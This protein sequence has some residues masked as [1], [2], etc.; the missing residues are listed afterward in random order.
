M[1]REKLDTGIDKDHYDKMG[2]R[3]TLKELAKEEDSQRH[4]IT[5]EKAALQQEDPAVDD[6]A[7]NTTACGCGMQPVKSARGLTRIHGSTIRR[8]CSRIP[9]TISFTILGC[10]PQVT[11]EPLST[12]AG[13]GVNHIHVGSRINQRNLYELPDEKGSKGIDATNNPHYKEAQ[14]PGNMF[15]STSGERLKETSINFIHEYADNDKDQM[16][17]R[18]ADRRKE[19]NQEIHN[20]HT[21]EL[22]ASPAPRIRRYSE[23]A[24]LKEKVGFTDSG[25]RGS[26]PIAAGSDIN[27]GSAR[28]PIIT[29]MAE[30][31]DGGKHENRQVHEQ[32]DTSEDQQDNNNDDNDDF[33]Y[34]MQST[35]TCSTRKRTRTKSRQPRRRFRRCPRDQESTLSIFFANVT[36]LGEQPRKHLCPRN[37]HIVGVAETH[38]RGKK[39]EEVE[40]KLGAAGLVVSHSPASISAKSDSG[41]HGG[42]MLLHKP[43]LQ[44]AIPAAAEGAKGQRLPEGDVA[45]KHFRIKGLHLI[46][47]SAYFEDGVGLQGSNLKK[48]HRLEELRGGGHNHLIVLG[49]F[50]V[51]PAEWHC[52]HYLNLLNC[53]IVT[54]GD[55]GTCKTRSGYSL[56]DYALVDNDIRG[57]VESFEQV[58]EVPWKPHVGLIMKINRRPEQIMTTQIIKT[59]PLPKTVDEKGEGKRWHLSNNDWNYH[60]QQ[61]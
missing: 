11:D 22:E 26:T 44:S 49:D 28:D 24:M 37:E 29:R 2:S 12:D 52:T 33:N 58:G 9:G 53:S 59:K 54:A 5:F 19:H 50:N 7:G 46:V 41:T 30:K 16:Q 25:G 8:M 20:H 55:E 1:I 6:W 31:T 38:L 42:T 39:A 21:K 47:A 45:W 48:I 57:L 43:W 14:D 17:P 10:M 3:R 32:G 4:I 60:L 61:C 36:Y 56:I 18:C 27:E 35:T 15:D 23:I 34:D 40:A 13:R 51:K